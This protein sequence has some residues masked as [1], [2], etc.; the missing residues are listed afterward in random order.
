[1]IGFLFKFTLSFIFCFVILSFQISNKPLFYHLSE[2]TGPIGNEVQQSIKKSVKRT[3]SKSKKISED[4][5]NN[6]DPK[7]TDAVNSKRSSTGSKSHGM[8]LEEINQ[9]DVKKL[10][11]IIK[12]N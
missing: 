2:F 9:K 1:M 5:L 11:E 8:V 3:Y 10:D 12:K 6:A 7:Y 4:F